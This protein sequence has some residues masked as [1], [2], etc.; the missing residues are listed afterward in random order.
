MEAVSKGARAVIDSRGAAAP[1]T[2]EVVGVVV[3]GIF[4]DRRLTGNAY[5]TRTIDSDSMLH[6]ID[7]MMRLA[8]YFVC[9]PGTMGT[10]QELTCVWMSA[11]LHPQT[12]AQP[13]I[14]AFRDP[15]ESCCRAIAATLNFP[16]D[17][18]E[19]IHFVDTPEEA[20]EIVLAEEARERAREAA[21]ATA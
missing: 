5:L 15:W 14:I 7:Q 4:P 21:A 2:C 20:M 12:C 9:L 11:V 13:V 10:L 16:P 6:R 1:E 3:S 17:Q 8:R 18:I 19:L